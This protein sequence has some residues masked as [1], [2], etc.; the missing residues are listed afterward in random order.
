MAPR[1][2]VAIAIAAV[3]TVGGL[4]GCGGGNE[5]GDATTTTAAPDTTTPK[6]L[7]FTD[8][9][10]PIVA[11]RGQVFAIQLESNVSTGFVWTIT[12]PPDP[13]L[14][15]VLTPEGNTE[16]PSTGGGVGSPGSTIFEF[17]GKASGT[18]TVTFTSAR[19]GDPGD[20][21]TTETFTIAI[22]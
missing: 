11:V 8:P 22:S 5:S 17:K 16:A 20:S 1:M 19:P 12:T 21:P 3:V 15:E 2:I 14:V 4:A 10:L 18:A 7:T 13:E 9:A 6:P